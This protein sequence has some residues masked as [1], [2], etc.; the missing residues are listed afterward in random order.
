M[1]EKE[2]LEG[3]MPLNYFINKSLENKGIQKNI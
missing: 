3:N 2:I 1:N